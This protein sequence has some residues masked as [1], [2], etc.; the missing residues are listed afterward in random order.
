VTGSTFPESAGYDW[1]ALVADLN[2]LLRL[3]TTITA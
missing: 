2:A 1:L 3:K